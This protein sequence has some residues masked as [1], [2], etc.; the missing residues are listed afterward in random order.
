MRGGGWW[1]SPAMHRRPQRWISRCRP[2]RPHR[3]PLV[4]PSGARYSTRG[5]ISSGDEENEATR[6]EETTRLAGIRRAERKEER[7]RLRR[8]VLSG[9]LGCY[10]LAR[11]VLGSEG[12]ILTDINRNAEQIDGDAMGIAPGDV[13]VSSM[14]DDAGYLAPLD[15]EPTTIPDVMRATTTMRRHTPPHGVRVDGTDARAE[16][17][18]PQTTR[19]NRG[20][21]S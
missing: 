18:I 21:T 7:A 8:A 4:P 16:V 20:C 5:V 12:R 3:R 1:R 6:R 14:M 2:T 15:D 11:A 17:Q 19:T 9:A 13:V 10:P